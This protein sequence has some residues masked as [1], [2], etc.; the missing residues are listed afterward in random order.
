MNGNIIGTGISFVGGSNV[1]ISGN[2]EN[3]TSELLVGSGAQVHISGN[4]GVVTFIIDEA[5]AVA[6]DGN[7]DLSERLEVAA[8]ASLDVNGNLSCDPGA[9]TSVDST[10]TIITGGNNECAALP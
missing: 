8:N 10:A 7:L 9:T 5:G 4:V 2:V 6:I 1:E 3:E